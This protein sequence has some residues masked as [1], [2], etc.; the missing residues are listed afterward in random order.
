MFSSMIVYPL[1]LVIGLIAGLFVGHAKWKRT[2]STLA[3]AASFSGAIGAYEFSRY[4]LPD[5]SFRDDP[6]TV[7]LLAAL[8]C[9]AFCIVGFLA[10]LGVRWFVANVYK[11]LFAE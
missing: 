3:F 9:V 6:M 1:A 7:L 8:W 2:L 5:E 4:L 11:L 10:G